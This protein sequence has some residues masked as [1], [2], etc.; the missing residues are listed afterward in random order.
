MECNRQYVS[1]ISY[2]WPVYTCTE[3]EIQGVPLATQPPDISLIILMPMKILQRNRHTLQTHS[4]SF[5]TQQT[6]S[7]SNFVTI[8][9]CVLELLKMPGSVASGTLC[10][11]YIFGYSWES[12]CFKQNSDKVLFLLNTFYIICNTVLIVMFSMW[13]KV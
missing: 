1:L 12:S 6:Y 5:L 11:F 2:L 4:S 8:S 9:S 3:I 13:F 10:I 7:F